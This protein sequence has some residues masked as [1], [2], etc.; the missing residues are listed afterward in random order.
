MFMAYTCA[1]LL[2]ATHSLL[3]TVIPHIVAAP[4]AFSGLAYVS[5]LCPFML[6]M[7]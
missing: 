4:L 3:Y 7:R 1:F 6:A 5:M 2:P